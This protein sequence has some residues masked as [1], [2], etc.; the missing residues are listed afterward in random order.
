MVAQGTL[1]YYDG[2]AF[3]DLIPLYLQHYQ[4]L[5]SP[6]WPKQCRGIAQDPAGHLWFGF[7]HVIRFD[8][9]S[10]HRY[11][12]D[13]GFPQA[14]ISYVLG[15][16]HTGEVWIGLPRHRDI[17]HY[18]ANGAFQSVQVDLVGGLRKIQCDREGRGWFCT[19]QGVLYQDG[20]GFSRFDAYRWPTPSHSQ[21]R[22]PRSRGSILVRH[23]GRRCRGLRCAW[24]RAFSTFGEK[25][26]ENTG[27]VSQLVQDRRGDIWIGYASS[28]LDPENKSVVRLEGERLVFVETDV[29]NERGEQ[30][31]RQLFRHPRGP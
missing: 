1:G 18:Y 20:D 26:P 19:S 23:V 15:Q 6:Q 5:P 27:E 25:R 2:T 17:L 24:Y 28:S 31:Y 29:E 7:D 4:Q 12:E 9:E 16:D 10:F 13:E 8:G 22:V 3:H 14:H 21:S 30:R 11:E